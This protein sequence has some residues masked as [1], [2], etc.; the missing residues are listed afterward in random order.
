MSPKNILKLLNIS[1]REQ[2][3]RVKSGIKKYTS[4]ESETQMRLCEMFKM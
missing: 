4:F 3:V 2:R 1:S